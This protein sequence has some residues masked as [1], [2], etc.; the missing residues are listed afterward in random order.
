MTA[1]SDPFQTQT[2]PVEI[3]IDVTELVQMYLEEY[4]DQTEITFA[5]SEMNGNRLHI[6]S[7]EGGDTAVPRLDVDI[8]ET[9]EPEETVSKKTLEFFLNS[10]KE[11]LAAGDADSCVQT[12]KDLLNEAIAEG[13]AVMADENATRD[14]VMDAAYKLM[15]AVQALGMKAADKTD[16]EMAVELARM[17]DLEDYVS[18]G[19]QEFTDALAEA[20]KVL[21]DGDAMQGDADDAW[22][23]LVDAMGGLRLKADKAVLEG[24]L[25]EAEEMDLSQYTEESAAQFRMAFASAQA[26]FADNELSVDDQQAVDSAA[27]ELRSAKAALVPVSE[28][29]G[30]EGQGGDEVQDPGEGSQGSGDTQAPDAGNQ[31]SGAG[32]DKGGNVDH[33]SSAASV[34]KAAKTG[35]E[36]SAAGLLAALALAAACGA[37]AVTAVR[38]KER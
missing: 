7:K 19:Q 38:R 22:N 33:N 16:L 31:G 18:A 36:A 27:A 4:P 8:R 14:E 24:L 2:A 5:L 9:Q 26:V 34:D 20:E 3:R 25:A 11:H 21:A 29:S 28:T 6:G 23:R 30:D 13:E 10:A 37:A 32:V 35:D 15:K 1:L 12:V 17:I